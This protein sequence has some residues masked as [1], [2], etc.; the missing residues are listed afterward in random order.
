MLSIRWEGSG[1]PHGE[2]LLSTLHWKKT[3]EEIIWRRKEKDGGPARMESLAAR[4]MP[5][6]RTLKKKNDNLILAFSFLNSI[7]FIFDQ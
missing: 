3:R 5:C 1:S 7:M 6:G 2:L 4:D